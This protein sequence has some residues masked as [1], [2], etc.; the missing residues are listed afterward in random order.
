[1]PAVRKPASTETA[2]RVS[3]F[4]GVDS[5]LRADPRAP[6]GARAKDGAEPPERQGFFDG[7]CP[8][9]AAGS[10]KAYFLAL[11]TRRV[12]EFPRLWFS[13]PAAPH[14][15]STASPGVPRGTRPARR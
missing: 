1:M 11:L 10:L 15:P 5:V 13:E 2:V 9:G 7:E 14:P 4:S 3:G 8:P 6:P 12:G